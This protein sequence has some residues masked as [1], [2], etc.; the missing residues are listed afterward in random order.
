[1]RPRTFGIILPLNG[2]IKKKCSVDI[3]ADD[4]EING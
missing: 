1:M 2:T 3:D 4:E